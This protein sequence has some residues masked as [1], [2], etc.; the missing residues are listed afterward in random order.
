MSAYNITHRGIGLIK[1]HQN[2]YIII[3]EREAPQ[4]ALIAN[5][6]LLPMYDY[7]SLL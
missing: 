2:A 6:L 7:P 5:Y 1:N 3:N 4:L